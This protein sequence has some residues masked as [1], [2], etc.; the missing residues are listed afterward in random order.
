MAA[1]QDLIREQ[2]GGDPGGLKPRDSRDYRPF[3]LAQSRVS[4]DYRASGSVAPPAL[5][6]TSPQAG[7]TWTFLVFGDQLA[8]DQ[9][10]DPAV[11]QVLDLGLVVGA[12]V[13]LESLDLPVVGL[14]LDLDLL[15]RLDRLEPTD[16]V[17]LVTRQAERLRVLPGRVLERQDSHTDEVRAVDALERLRDHGSDTQEERTLRRPVA[18]RSGSVLLAGEH[19]R[20]YPLLL[21]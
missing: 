11:V 10:Q 5:R 4:R 16:R 14:R 9:G 1:D 2:R 3:S 15:T 7:R 17:A 21:V 18:R 12:R 19:D 20:R 6:A 8:E 13:G